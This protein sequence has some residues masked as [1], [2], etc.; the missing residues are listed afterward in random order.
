MNNLK[1]II[2]IFLALFLS[3][4]IVLAGLYVMNEHK[5]SKLITSDEL[6][7]DFNKNKERFETVKNYLLKQDENYSLYRGDYT[8]IIQ[9]ENV[10]L[11]LEFIF[12]Q[13]NCYK[14]VRCESNDIN[15]E[16]KREDDWHM[17]ITYKE[18]LDNI[19]NYSELGGNWYY[20]DFQYDLSPNQVKEMVQNKLIFF[21]VVIILSIGFYLLIG[22]IPYFKKP[23]NSSNV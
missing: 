20:Y 5:Y 10:N 23:K 4:V 11:A 6:T 7:A 14:I 17:I 21:A 15:F 1:K 19:Q 8:K 18:E 16:Y 2:Q 12:T 3:F 22:L 13:P 9:D